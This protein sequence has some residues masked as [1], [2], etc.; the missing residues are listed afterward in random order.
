MTVLHHGGAHSA[1]VW[2]MDV[3]LKGARF[4]VRMQKWAQCNVQCTSPLGGSTCL[5]RV[6][7]SSKQT[8]HAFCLFSTNFPLPAII[9]WDLRP[10]P[11]SSSTEIICALWISDTYTWNYMYLISS[12][13]LPNCQWHL[14]KSAPSDCAL[15]NLCTTNLAR[16]S[17]WV[18]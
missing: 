2:N 17:L 15:H 10:P 13:I 5:F 7:A 3:G 14:S 4:W 16:V 11:L 6:S 12:V 9:P 1:A 8:E 18:S